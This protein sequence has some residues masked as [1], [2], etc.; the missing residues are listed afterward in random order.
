V[1]TGGSGPA[2]E[3]RER[4]QERER[5]GARD[6]DRDR[7]KFVTERKRAQRETRDMLSGLSVCF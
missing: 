6:R 4:V 3:G 7:E 1:E 2:G 5:D